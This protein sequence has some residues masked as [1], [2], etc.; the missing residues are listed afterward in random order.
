MKE[1][2]GR[3]G[4][5]MNVKKAK[6]VVVCRDT[7]GNQRI[8]FKVNGEDLEQ[9]DKFKYLGQWI[10]EDGTCDQEVK[11][12]IEMARTAFIKMRDIFCSRS[13]DLSLK[14]E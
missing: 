8:F 9:V 11:C 7:E 12:R 3:N 6:T 1:Q 13:L 10:N 14:I 4:L 5:K 2:S